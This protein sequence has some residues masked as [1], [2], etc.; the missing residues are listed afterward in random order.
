MQRHCMHSTCLALPYSPVTC[1]FILSWFQSSNF[2]AVVFAQLQ[3]TLSQAK[4]VDSLHT[5]QNFA[6]TWRVGALNWCA[7]DYSLTLGD[8]T[9]RK[10]I[11][12]LE[13]VTRKTIALKCV[14]TSASSMSP[15]FE[16]VT[17]SGSFITCQPACQHYWLLLW[18][19]LSWHRDQDIDAYAIARVWGSES[20]KSRLKK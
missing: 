16:R 12:K 3:S 14:R 9:Q 17:L 18:P 7:I 4:V 8:L 1:T 11:V 15:S 5:L 10:C 6:C 13:I 19:T 20:D 2:V